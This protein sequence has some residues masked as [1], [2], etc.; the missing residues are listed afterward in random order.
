M[1]GY[2]IIPVDEEILYKLQ[3]YNFDTQS[4]RKWVEA[5]KHNYLTTAYYLLLKNH[6]RGGGVS[7]ADISVD[8][9]DPKLLTPKTPVVLNFNNS[10]HPELPRFSVDVY[11]KEDRRKG[12]RRP[13]S[14]LPY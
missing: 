4:A 13:G 7:I 2:D 10:P 9:I 6:I 3:D 14:S 8:Y 12:R 11:F 1:I 5:N